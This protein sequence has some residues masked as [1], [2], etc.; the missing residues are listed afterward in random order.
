MPTTVEWIY[1][2][3]FAAA[4]PLY[5]HVIAWPR[6]LRRLR[7]TPERARLGEY[8]SIIVIQWVLTAAGL[9]LWARSGRAWSDVGL[10]APEGWRLWV[11]VAL[12]LVMS[13][14]NARNVAGVLRSAKARARLRPRLASVDAIVPHTA[15]ELAGFWPVSLTA[16]F[17]EE[18]LFR[19]FL[20]WALTPLL[21]WWGAVAASTVVFGFG[22]SYQGLPGAI[23]AGAV[24]LAMALI[25]GLTHSLMAA[26]VLHALIDMGSG[27]V[28]W[29]VVRPEEPGDAASP[30]SATTPATS[31]AVAMA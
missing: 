1:V 20:V 28:S 29:I 26:V 19:G 4:W 2:A 15:R 10:A 9:A 17:C 31:G 12:V 3:L 25:Y 14:L 21:T 11:S 6:F 5:E 16:G 18:F 13:T 8:R 27:L 24:G 30:E 22:H 7:E 23:R